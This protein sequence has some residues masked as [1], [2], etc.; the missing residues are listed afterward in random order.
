ME[1]KKLFSLV[2]LVSA[3]AVVPAFAMEEKKEGVEEVK[4]EANKPVRT[5]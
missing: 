1:M 3:F 5:A 4:V 2:L